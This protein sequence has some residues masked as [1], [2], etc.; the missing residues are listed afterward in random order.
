MNASTRAL[1][2]YGESTA[3]LD[4]R[5]ALHAFGTSPLTWAEFVRRRLPM[6]S[7]QRVL[8]AGAGT[9]VHWQLPTDVAPLL[10]D[11]HQPMC[12][13]LV[14]LPS[15]V[16][17][18]SVEALP[19]PDDSMGGVLCT[20]VLYHVDDPDKAVDELVRVL[21]PGG[22]LAIAS[23]GPRHMAEL[24]ALRRSVG[25]VPESAHCENFSIVAAVEAMA[26]RRLAPVRHDFDDDLRVTDADAVVAY[27]ETLDWL[28]DS[29]RREMRESVAAVIAAKDHFPVGKEAALVLGH[30]PW[31]GA[32]PL[33]D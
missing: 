33:A 21:K 22:W 16:V 19:F 5:V 25:V 18:G 17:Q 13:R 10:M 29:Q 6:V 32:R 2:Q 4:A 24:D 28:T 12:L 7:G 31:S 3:N 9:G 15:P 14:A 1:Q 8:D 20:H 30:K 26:S 11:A 27:C 23:N